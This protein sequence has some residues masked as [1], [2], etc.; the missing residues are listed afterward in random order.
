M[1][2]SEQQYLQLKFTMGIKN[3]KQS[4]NISTIPKKD[5]K[6]LIL[7]IQISLCSHH[8]Q[9]SEVTENGDISEKSD[10]DNLKVLEVIDQ[11][12]ITFTFS[13]IGGGSFWRE[14]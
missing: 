11:D 1:D 5:A 10:A 3:S 9:K 13:G 2:L 12:L 7:L 14:S 6:V 4:V 8:R